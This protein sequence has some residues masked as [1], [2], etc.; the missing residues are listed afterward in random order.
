MNLYHKCER[1]GA[2]AEVSGLVVSDGAG[3]P[4]FRDRDD[5]IRHWCN[6]R[7]ICAICYHDWVLLTSQ[8]EEEL[9]VFFGGDNG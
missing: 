7:W 5:N 6:A 1:C 3:N 9:E 4:T 8:Q 2:E